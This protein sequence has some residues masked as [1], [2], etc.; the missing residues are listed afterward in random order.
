TLMKVYPAVIAL[1]ATA[2]DLTGPSRSRDQ[3]LM[4]FAAAVLLGT[5][6]WLAIGETHEI[7]ESLG[8]QLDRG[9]EYGSLYSGAQM[10]AAKAI[11]N[12]IDV[13]RDHAA[14]SSVTLWSPR[15]LPLVLPIQAATI[16]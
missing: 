5:L 2:W 16:L 3:G 4:T 11:E 15:L 12:E 9:F 7:S 1:V 10:L 14:W 8:Y 6:A 13:L